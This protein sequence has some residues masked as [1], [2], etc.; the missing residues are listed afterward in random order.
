MLADRRFLRH[1]RMCPV[2]PKNSNPTRL[3]KIIALV[4]R[5]MAQRPR[6]VDTSQFREGARSIFFSVRK[7]IMKLGVYLVCLAFLTLLRL[8]TQGTETIAINYVRSSLLRFGQV[9][10]IQARQYLQRRPSIGFT[11]NGVSID[12]R[13]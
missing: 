5:S 6:L 2:H 9:H 4:D 7:W 8:G 3:P 1:H 11:P 13:A 10:T 12:W